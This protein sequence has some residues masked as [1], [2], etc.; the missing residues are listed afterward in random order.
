MEMCQ[1]TQSERLSRPAGT[2]ED[3]TWLVEG[4][5]GQ[6]ECGFV[7]E[8]EFRAFTQRLEVGDNMDRKAFE[9]VLSPDKVP[10]AT[11]VLDDVQ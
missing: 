10:G 6:D 7:K 8:T 5:E 11:I 4:F 1:H 3:K 2:K 9:L